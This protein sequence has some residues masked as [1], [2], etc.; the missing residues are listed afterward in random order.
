MAKPFSLLLLASLGLALGG[1]GFQPLYGDRSNGASVENALLD[2]AIAPQ[3]T[4]TG[5]LIRNAILSG[6]A[7]SATGSGRRILEFTVSEKEKASIVS[8]NSG[9]RQR[10]LI[11]DV[12]FILKDR[13]SRRKLF[14][15]RTF[16]EVSYTVTRQPAADMQARINARE[17]AAR[18]VGR[19]LRTRLAAWLAS[20]R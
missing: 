5:Q 19:D 3:R 8:F 9:D 20:H 17:T 14:S 10:R 15:G 1:C 16:S 6:I 12:D 4:R 11:L 7:P 13:A 2:I 18:V